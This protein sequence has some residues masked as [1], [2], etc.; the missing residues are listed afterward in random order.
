V[1]DAVARAVPPVDGALAPLHQAMRYTLE[2]GGKRIRPVVCLAS[3]EAVGGPEALDR[4]LAPAAALELVH[5]YSL[6]HDD[7]PC[8]DD[9]DVRR[10][11]P[12]NHR[13]HGEALAVLAGDGLLTRAF[14]VLAEA[15]DLPGGTRIEMV[16][17]LAEAAGSLGMVGG[18]A[19]DVAAE[20]QPEM[21]LP[22]LQFIHTHKTG[23]LFS[24]ACR[25][26]ALAGGGDAD[27]VRRL[28]KLGEKLGL[29]FQVADDLLDELGRSEDLR[30]ASG[31]DRERGKATY[32]RLLGVDESKRR[33]AQLAAAADELAGAFGERAEALRTV[34]RFVAER[35]Q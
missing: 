32:P 33:V 10:G 5:T 2:S 13:A 31:R 29:A 18:Q 24:A 22:R 19:L 4:A 6:I 14:G 17:V 12:S 3:C 30:K 23:A 1:D 16:G 27:A 21:D 35:A 9:D 34:I 15:P 11:K 8:M 7:L 28:G 25:L 26:G 20:G